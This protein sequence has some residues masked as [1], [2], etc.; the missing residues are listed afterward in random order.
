LEINLCMLFFFGLLRD[1]IA[2][3]FVL[4]RKIVAI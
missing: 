2:N 3:V 4:I 1:L